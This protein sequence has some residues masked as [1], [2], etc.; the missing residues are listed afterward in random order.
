MGACIFFF[1]DDD[2][3][4]IT[5]LTHCQHRTQAPSFGLVLFTEAVANFVCINADGIRT[6]RKRLLLYKLLRDLQVALC[7]VTETHLREEEL[8]KVR[9]PNY[10]R[11]AE[12]CREIPPG[13]RPGGGVLIMAHQNFS[14]KSSPYVEEIQEDIEHCACLFFPT[15]N[16][17]T[18]LRVTGI[19]IP[20]P[21]IKTLTMQRLCSLS[22]PVTNEV[23]GDAFP[24]IMTGDFNA[25]S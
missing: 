4:P 24:H 9:T 15:P 3:T 23:T 6:Q 1:D 8:P 13:V 16:P 18:A 22:A 11:V 20:P 14:T 17:K 21:K 10:Y 2:I 25:T 5:H 12:F 19:Y 7:V